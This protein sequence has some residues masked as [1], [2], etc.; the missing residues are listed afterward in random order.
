MNGG[1][2]PV[3][4]DKLIDSQLDFVNARS[5]ERIEAEYSACCILIVQRERGLLERHHGRP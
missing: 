1:V 4:G 5:I 2:N 3:T